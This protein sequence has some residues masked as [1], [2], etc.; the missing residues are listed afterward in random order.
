MRKLIILGL[1]AAIAAPAAVSAQP[2]E[3]RRD[4]RQ[5]R[6]EQREYQQARRFG[7][8]GDIRRERR[9]VRDARQDLRDS[10][11]D[12]PVYV[13]P[14]RGWQYRPVAQGY[15]LQPA[16]YGPRYVIADPRQYR[17]P[18]AARS[19]RWIRYGG[20]LLLVN[21]RNGRVIQVVRGRY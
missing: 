19:Q 12:R 21:A 4:Q 15:R 3:I 9:D 11:R 13:A 18:V 5:L 10:R 2:G 14:V 8:R 6:E 20:D 7:D 17:L 1:M 16:F